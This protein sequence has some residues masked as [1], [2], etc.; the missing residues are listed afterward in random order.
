M[1]APSEAE[2]TIVAPEVAALLVDTVPVEDQA[3][4]PTAL[5]AGLRY[6]ELRALRRERL[7]FAAGEIDVKRSWDPYEGTKPA[8]ATRAS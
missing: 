7:D 6:G 5:E 2:V 3:I 4:W 1:P 8:T